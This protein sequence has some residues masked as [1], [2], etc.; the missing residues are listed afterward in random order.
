VFSF[1]HLI[2]SELLRAV[3]LEPELPLYVLAEVLLALFIVAFVGKLST[4]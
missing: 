1:G 2:P 4:I 3:R